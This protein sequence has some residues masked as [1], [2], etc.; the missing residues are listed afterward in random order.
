V[1]AAPPQLAPPVYPG[2]EVVIPFTGMAATQAALWQADRLCSGLNASIRIVRVLL[3]P[4]PLDLDHPPSSVSFAA[5][6]LATLTCEL[7]LKLDI[8]LSRERVPALLDAVTDRSLVLL[9]S[10]R[11]LWRTKEERLARALNRRGYPV[12]LSYGDS[13]HA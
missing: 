1:V 13:N 7:T 2:I 4:Y 5:E 10:K 11:R 8:R 3:V 9:V 12:L 6:Q